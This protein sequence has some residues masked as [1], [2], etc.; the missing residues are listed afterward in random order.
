MARIIQNKEMIMPATPKLK[1]SFA[2]RYWFFSNDSG[3][4][5]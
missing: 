4:F 1:P 5:L 3:L 2:F